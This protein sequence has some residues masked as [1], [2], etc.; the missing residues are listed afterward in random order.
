MPLYQLDEYAET[1]IAQRISMVKGVAQVQVMGAQKFAV[2]VQV[3]PSKLA[4]KSVGI[5][6]IDAAIQTG[7]STC[8]PARFTDLSSNTTCRPPDSSRRPPHTAPSSSPGATE[9]RSGWGDRQRHR[10]RGRRKR[11]LTAQSRQAR[12]PPRH[13]PHGLPPA[14]HQH[15]RSQRQDQEAPACLQLHA[16]PVGQPEHPR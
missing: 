15:H 13:L 14:G 5:N 11:S 16:P 4:A 1:M 12:R 2:H 9:R 3:D 6:E 10:Q 8:P 7:T